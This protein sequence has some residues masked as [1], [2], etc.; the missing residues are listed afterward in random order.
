[1]ANLLSVNVEDVEDCPEGDNQYSAML[2]G[3]IVAG[4]KLE[5]SDRTIM[6]MFMEIAY[7][8][9]VT[10]YKTGLSMK[11]AVV[12]EASSVSSSGGRVPTKGEATS[13]E[14]EKGMPWQ[15]GLAISSILVTGVVPTVGELEREGWNSD[16]AK[17]QSAKEM[18]KQKRRFFNDYLDRGDAAGYRSMLLKG[19]DRLA[20]SRWKEGTS[21]LMLF[22][23]KLSK[24]TFDQQMPEL[25]L[26]YCEEHIEQYPGLGL[27][28]KGE[29]LD[30]F[31][32]QEYVI[33]VKAPS[34]SES[35]LAE[36][37][38][39]F[40]AA[41]TRFASKL[42]EQANHFKQKYENL[43][44]QMRRNRGPPGPDNPCTYCKATDHFIA[45]CPKKKLDMEKKAA[46]A[47]GSS[48]K[49]SD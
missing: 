21:D 6:D 35:K 2:L 13:I 3:H 7:A 44:S 18:R 30:A 17:W 43:E 34:D 41:E 39:K 47:G 8:D 19:A 1:M 20:A 36:M 37:T 29:P 45:D 5:A 15:C 49:S 10:G 9:E 42:A 32:L 48:S 22:V 27:C 14:K 11:K 16:P 24:M 31:I 12:K 25:F 28:K 4:A 40:E 46:A 38:K 26:S 23:T 33:S